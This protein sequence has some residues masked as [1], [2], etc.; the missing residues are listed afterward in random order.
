MKSKSDDIAIIGMSGKF[1]GAN[2]VSELWENICAKKESIRSLSDDELRKAGVS[3]QDINDST[4]VKVAALLDDYDLFDPSFFKISPLEAELMDPQI[5]LLLQC[6]WETLEDAGY[7]QKEAQN[8][9]VFAGAGGITASYFTHFINQNDRFEKITASPTQLGNDKDF[10]ATYPSYKLNLTGPSVTVQT[11][12]STSLVALHQARLS[13]LGGECDMALAGGVSIRVPH[14]QGYHYKEGYIFSK[15]GH[16]KTFDKSADGVVF[17]SGLGLVLIKK[18]SAAIRDGDH[19]YA[20][21]KGSAIVNDGKGKLSYAASSARGQI[22]CVRVALGN[23]G[24]EADSI[25]FVEAHGTGTA[26]GDPEE[27]KALSA[28]FKEQTDK[29]AYCALGAVKTN[30]GHLEAASGIV[31]FIKAVLAVKYGL[32]PPTPNYANPNPRI[33]F[34]NSPFYVN[35]QLEQWSEGKRP[36]RAA[37]NS[38]G[39]GGTNAFVILEQHV[40]TRTLWKKAPATPCVI[41]LS[42]KSESSLRAYAQRLA[43]FLAVCTAKEEAIH[44]ADVAYTLQVGREAMEYR[45]AFVVS[46]LDALQAALDRYLQNGEM[47]YGKGDAADLAAAWVGTADVDW[48]K[49]YVGVK[50]QRVS[51]PTYVFAQERYWIENENTAPACAFIHPLLHTN[52]SEL[53]EQKYSSSF[54]GEETFLIDHQVRSKQHGVNGSQ[55]RKILPGVAYLEMARAAIEQAVPFDYKDNQIQLQDILW[56]KPIVVPEERQVNIA[57]VAGDVD[58]QADRAIDFEIYT[59]DD[60]IHCQGRCLLSNESV[61]D[62]IDTI[63][64]KES[65]HKGRQSADSLYAAFAEMGLDYGPAHRAITAI[66]RGERELLAQLKLPPTT[67]AEQTNYVLHPS[68]M[69]GALQAAT[70]LLFDQDGISNQHPI[71]PFALS[72]LRI[73]APCTTEMFAWARHARNSPQSDKSA[74]LDVDLLDQQGNL[75]VQIRGF[76]PRPLDKEIFG[77]LLA[78]RVWQPSNQAA[79][80]MECVRYQ[81]ILCDLPHIDANKITDDCVLLELDSLADIAQCYSHLALACFAKAQALIKSRPQDK[82]LLQVV[83][84]NTEEQSVYAGL[85]GLFKTVSM[86][87][88]LILGQILLVDDAIGTDELSDL[89]DADRAHPHDTLI[90]YEKGVRHTTSWQILEENE[91]GIFDDDS[92]FKEWG[93]YLITGGLGR[94]GALFAKEILGRVANASIILTGQ[95]APEELRTLADKRAILT[96]LQAGGNTVEYRQLDLNSLD[97]VCEIIAMI[98]E[99]HG[100]LNGIIHSAGMIADNF[101]LKKTAEDFYRVLAPKVLGTFHLDQATQD[102]DLDFLVLFSSLTSATGNPG[103]ADYAAANGFMDEY[104]AHRNRLGRAGKRRGF[105]LAIRW[106]LWRDGGMQPHATGRDMLHETTGIHPMQT[107]TG[108]RM[109]YRSLAFPYDQ[110]LVMEGDL[111]SMQRTLGVGATARAAIPTL[112]APQQAPSCATTSDLVELTESYLCKQLSVLLKLPAHRIDPQALLEDYGIDSILALDLTGLLEKTFGPLSKTLFF[113]YLTI[114]ELAGYFVKAH[115]DQ[116]SQLFS[117]SNRISSHKPGTTPIPARLES[118]SSIRRGHPHLA[119]TNSKILAKKTTDSADPIA[120]IGLSG[121]YPGG[122]NLEEFWHN[123]R[124]GKDCIIEVP[125][126]RWDWREYYSADRSEQGCHYSKWGGFIEGVD[127]FDARFFHISPLEAETIDPQE[128]LFLEHA[129]MAIEDAGYTR[130]S[131]Q[132][133]EENNLTAQVGVY[134][135]VM[136]GEYQLFGAEASL[137]GNRMGF[138]SN[139]AS[140]ANRVSYFLN[141]HGPSMAV[142]TMCSSSL[143]AIHLACQDLELERTSLGIAGGVNV[144]IH[145]NKY[146][147]LSAGQFISSDGHCQSFGE[148]GD[149]YIPGEGVGV[150]VL[151]QLSAAQR[152]GNH[153]YGIIR[154]SALSHG[155]K[156][157]GYTVPNPQAQ[158]SAIRRALAEANVNPRHISYIEAHGTGTKLGDPIEIA[159]LSKVFQESTQDNEFCLIGS[160]KSNIGHCEAAAGIAGL[161]KAL[162]QLKHQAIVPSLHSSRL[163]PHIDFRNSPFVVNQSLR[164]WEQPVVEGATLPRIAGVSSFGAGGS[165]AHLIVEEYLQPITAAH[166]QE[167]VEVIVPLSARTADQLRMKARDLLEFVRDS[168][169]PLVSI[170]YTLQVGREAMEERLCILATSVEALADKLQAYLEGRTVPDGVYQGQ[171]KANKEA[172][173]LLE[174]DS[175]LQATIDK[176]IADGKLAKLADLWARGLNLNWHGFHAVKPPLV[177]LP[178][179]P[180][181][182]QR[183]WIETAAAAARQSPEALSA[184]VLHPLLHS[185]T[186]DFYQQSYTATFEGREFF[187]A[188]TP[189]Q[190]YLMEAACLEMARAAIEASMPAPKESSILELQDVAWAQP[191]IVAEKQPLGITLFDKVGEQVKFEIYR[192]ADGTTAT[193]DLVHCQGR[194]TYSDQPAPARIDRA[195]LEAEGGQS[196]TQLHLAAEFEN[197]QPD[198]VLHPELVQTA[199]QAAVDLTEGGKHPFSMTLLRVIFPCTKAKF[200]WARQSAVIRSAAERAI[201]IDL[202]DENGNVCVQMRGLRYQPTND[203]IPAAP[204][205]DLPLATPQPVALADVDSS[206][207]TP[208]RCD[209]ALSIPRNASILDKPYGSIVLLA[210]DASRT[211]TVNASQSGKPKVSLATTAITETRPREEERTAS[212]VSLFE[213]G[214]GVFSMHIHAPQS[215]NALSVDLVQD[216]LRALRAVELSSTAKVLTIEGTDGS[217]LTGGLESHNHAVVSG[218][219]RAIT[220]FPYPVVAVAGGDTTGAGFLFASVCDFIICSEVARYAFTI[221]REGLY[222]SAA[223]HLF[224]ERYG[225][226]QA[227]DFLYLSTVATGAELKSKGWTCPILPHD[228]VAAQ[229][230]DLAANLAQKPQL[231]LR[232]LKQQLVQHIS[233]AVQAL[234]VADRFP[235]VTKESQPGTMKIPSKRIRLDVQGNAVL[236]VTISEQANG[237]SAKDLLADLATVFGKIDEISPYR[238]VVLTSNLAGFLPET[239][240]ASHAD[241]VQGYKQAL[242]ALKRPIVAALIADATGIAW[243]V[244]QFCDTCLY[245]EQGRYSC[246]DILHDPKLAEEAAALFSLRFGDQVAKEILMAGAACSG[247]ELRDIYGAL[248]VFSPKQ[249]LPDALRLADALAGFPAPVLAGWKKQTL[250]ILQDTAK[251]LEDG[252]PRLAETAQATTDA[253][254]AVALESRVISAIAHPEGILEVH[255]ADHDAHNMFSDAF[256]RGMREVFAH[257]EDSRTYKVVVLTGYDHY[258]ASGAT[259]DTLLAIFEGKAKFTDNK[260]F[261]LPLTCTVPVIAAMQG[262]GIG[263][264]WAM[265]MYADFALFSETGRYLSPYMGYGFTPGAG[266]TLIFLEKMGYDLAREGLLSAREY[267][268]AELKARG[269]RNPVLARELV[270]PAAMTLAKRIAQGSRGLLVALKRRWAERLR[271]DL[272][273]TFERELAMHARTI[274]G[275]T[276]TLTRIQSSF[277]APSTPLAQSDSTPLPVPDESFD[278]IMAS[279]KKLLAHELR[280]QEQEIGEDEQFVDL[281]LDSITGVTWIRRINETYATSIEATKIYSYPTLAQLARYVQEQMPQQAAPIVTPTASSVITSPGAESRTIAANLRRLLAHELRMQENEIGDDEQFVDLGLDSITGV[282]WMRKINE[283]YKISIE[284][285]K[286]YSYPTLMQLSRYVGEEVAKLGAFLD[287]PRVDPPVIPVTTHNLHPLV[288][289]LRSWRDQSRSKGVMSETTSGARLQPIAVIGMAGQF[290]Q[291]R[292]LEKFWQNIAEG[293][294]C[295]EEIPKYRWNIDSYYQEG[296]AVPGKTYS[297]WMGLLEEY[298]RFDAG[299]FNISPREARSMDPQQRLFLQACWHSIEHAGYNPKSLSGSNCGVFVGCSAGDYHQL[300]KHEQLSGQGFT[301]A[302]PSVLAARISYFLDLHGPSLSIDTAC[303]SSLVAIAS[304]CDSLISNSSDIALAGGVN[305]MSSPAMQIMTAQVGML[306]PQGRCL[307]FDDKADGIVNGEGVGVLMLKRLADAQRDRDWIYGVLEGWGVNQDGR[308]N[309][310]TAPNADL[311]A[312]LQQE[313]YDRFKIDPASIQLIEAHGTGTALGDPIEVAGLKASFK[314]YTCEKNYCALGS[315]KSNI[316][317]CLT[318]AGVSGVIKTLLALEHQQLPP[319]IHFHTLNKHISLQDSPFYIN[320]RLR[321]WQQKDGEPRRA[322]INSFGFSGTNAHVVIAEYQWPQEPAAHDEAA[323]IPLSARTANQ[324]QQKAQ[325]LLAIVNVQTTVTPGLHDIAYTLQV[326]R[327]AM[328]ERVAFIA[329]TIAELKH[330]L[331]AFLEWEDEQSVSPVDTMYR[332]KASGSQDT[333]LTLSSDADFQSMI[334]KWIDKK[335]LPRL[336]D[337]WVKGLALDWNNFYIAEKSPRRIGLPTYPFAKERYWIDAPADTHSPISATASTIIHPLL[338]TNTSDLNQQK[339]TTQLAGDEFFLIDC[340][341]PEGGKQQVFPASACLEM[342]RVAVENAIPDLPQSATIEL[343]AIKWGQPAKVGQIA[344]ALSS[345]GTGRLAFDIF[346]VEQ[347]EVIHCQ[348]QVALREATAAETLDCSLRQGE[349]RRGEQTPEQLYAAFA[350]SG[351]RYSAMQRAIQEILPGDGELLVRLALPAAVDGTLGAYRIHPI[352]MDGAI[353]AGILLLGGPGDR[354]TQMLSP[355]TIDSVHVFSP[356]TQEMFAR[357]RCDQADPRL[358]DIDLCDEYGNPCVQV[359]GMALEV[360]ESTTPRSEHTT[361]TPAGMQPVAPITEQARAATVQSSVSPEQ[362]QQQLKA[363]LAEALFMQPADVDI[364]K[365]FTELGL[366]S[367]IGVEWVNVINK[368]YGTDIAATRIYDYPSIRELASF[369]SKEMADTDQSQDVADTKDACTTVIAPDNTSS[370]C[371]PEARQDVSLSLRAQTSRHGR[372]ARFARLEPI[373][374]EPKYSE[375]FKELYFYSPDGAGDFDATGEFSVQYVINPD[376]NLCLREHVVFDEHLLPTDAY[377]ELVHCAYQAYFS[378]ENIYLRDIAIVNPLLGNKGRDTY[379]QIVFRRAGDDLQFFVKSSILPTFKDSSLHMQGFV[380]IAGE[381]PESGFE[382]DFPIEKEI[383]SAEIPT[384]TGIY[385]APLQALRFGETAAIGLIKV[386]DHAFEFLV[387]PFVLYGGLCTVINFG[388]YLAGKQDRLGN[389]QFLPYRIGRIRA[390]GSLNGT[391]YRCYAR[392]KKLER[393]SIEFD[394]EILDGSEQPVLTIDTIGLRRVAKETIQQQAAKVKALPLIESGAA[395]DKIAII[396][397][398][399]RY[400]MSPDIDAFWNN[401]KAGRDCIT[402][403]P[404]KR[405]SNHADWYHPDPSHAHTSYSKWGGFLDDIDTFDALFFGISPAEAEVIDPQ[406]RIFLE[407]CWKTIE[408]AGYASSAL[409]NH[410]CGVYV[411]CSTGDYSRVLANG[412]QDTVGAAFMGTSNAILAARVSYHL[413]LKGPALAIDTACSS[414]LVAVHLACESIRSGENQLALAGGI[415]ILTTPIGHILT[416]QV[417]MPSRD[418][419]CPAFD[420]SANGIVFSEGCGVLL[421]KALSLAKRDNDNILGVI[422]GSGINQDGKTNGITAPSSNAQEQLLKQVYDKFNIDPQRIGYVEAHGTATPLGDPIEV[423][424]LSSV[425]GRF[426]QEKKYCA[427]GSVKSNI[428]HTG[429]AAGVAGILKVLLCIKHKKLVPSIHYHKPN[430][431]IDFENSP[432]FVNTQYCDWVSDQPLLATVSSFGFSGTNAHVV[433]EE[434]LSL[435]EPVQIGSGAVPNT[436]MFVPLSARTPEQLGQKARDLLGFIHNAEYP[437]D[438]AQMAHTLLVG[439][440]AMEHRLGFIVDS[441]EQLAVKLQAYLDGKVHIDDCYRGQ[442]GRDND[443]LA[444]FAGDMEI[445]DLIRRWIAQNNLPKI[446]DLWVKGFELDGSALFDGARPTRMRLPTYP[447]AKERCWISTVEPAMPAKAENAMATLHPLLHCNTSDLSQQSYSSTFDGNEFFLADHRVGGQQMLPAVAYLEMARAALADAMPVQKA[448]LD[449]ELHHI[450]WTQPIFV[451]AKQD[452]EIAVFS[453]QD[454]Q[455]GF[456]I[457]SQ[458]GDDAEDILHCQGSAII[459]DQTAEQRLDLD[460]L[461]R[462]MSQGSLEG[463]VLYPLFASMGLEYGPTFQGITALHRGENQLLVELNL[464][465]AARKGSG[466]YVLHPSLMDA[467][468]QG[469]ITLIDDVMHGSGKRSLPFALDSLRILSVCTERMVAWVRYAQGGRGASSNLIKVDIDLCDADGNVCVQMRG[470]S[471]RPMANVTDFDEAHYRSVIAGISNREISLDE[472]VELG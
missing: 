424:A 383:G 320:D 39:I 329:S 260:V 125:K 453:E 402:E 145:P 269:L 133:L 379:V 230:Q 215:R 409:S 94:L 7:A 108:M 18:L 364:H 467:A 16:V 74:R 203:H 152:D 120:I 265:G 268:G 449:L 272:P 375:R 250:S 26:M 225:L 185:N 346:S 17:G 373:C 207:I 309:G 89:L 356:C 233:S 68:L 298:D 463:S 438:L 208:D 216:I 304:A 103:Q 78:T 307:A 188:G 238:C 450:V 195:V 114:R 118:I 135:G 253:P 336:A 11:A 470:F 468:L 91:P 314:K 437:L 204:S 164:S 5:R 297:K 249:V 242:L 137:Q 255:M 221:A 34:E 166:A 156:T 317:H 452:I 131:L 199:L 196:L 189:G 337:L 251:H 461:R 464:P 194:A 418:G 228:K 287:S 376:N 130:A 398:S 77:S 332:G 229:A 289:S 413:N 223:D 53:D 126:E 4:Y 469:S 335:E 175:D 279:I 411:G 345:Q 382:A 106:P 342:T 285:T 38:L 344:I 122:R 466:N 15:S 227:T 182:R 458:D 284:A 121:R 159:A 43:N 160:V 471:S 75:C 393:E 281:G 163:N 378:P 248:H 331:R 102:L 151:K 428:G 430:P 56:F 30:V 33:K 273:A 31:G 414:S 132:T 27:V 318:A 294:D 143:T 441:T 134:A 73:V 385:Y 429:F 136:Y 397:M 400:P 187:L 340:D 14:V 267:S 395:A 147:M 184:A 79:E 186:S 62:R 333:L 278:A 433:I 226:V 100:Q 3:E 124:N 157:N 324:L 6:A 51:L 341:T 202:F 40:P 191:G 60:Q 209:S 392:V 41:P 46:T 442:T 365:S 283:A 358:A 29:K 45:V 237:C 32:I 454:A 220:E 252:A 148:G 138:A 162:L 213:H 87:N 35:G 357:V 8:I 447:F 76:M 63:Q 201:D 386:P 275:Q 12:C 423:N 451:S 391:D 155:G 288:S 271:E 328:D 371:M 19:I 394:F 363:S 72:S 117:D 425:F 308:T 24:V 71:V 123:L 57:V 112:A 431:H 49:L 93:V 167:A 88:S 264:G 405:W 177:S 64:L 153:I 407:E 361:A 1:P 460:R 169:P 245:S 325:D 36:R 434:H 84:P 55:W 263:A 338:H 459:S 295:I 347:E 257:V 90:K 439:R 330:K 419:R 280:M 181:A 243:H 387:S 421:L 244:A 161:T 270:V 10:L 139:L 240:A 168:P 306:S 390:L 171:V 266:S 129:W 366:D 172:L 128:R 241:V 37:V 315:V 300:S 115:A 218:L 54:T 92:P 472:A 141:L 291:A 239:S 462:Q 380:S 119:N 465:E 212:A 67:I 416:S 415:N 234:T 299:F 350:K 292:D 448:W 399:C 274:A 170:A 443:M 97:Q 321:P 70:A 217:F 417:G 456:E 312:R 367:I 110:T 303:S 446:V 276:D 258:F 21:I 349:G 377:I 323:I 85:S 381:F 445:R 2:S 158:A 13:L 214:N 327:E 384:N 404:A 319:T 65:M 313:V 140:I 105:T 359:R 372:A 254:I 150:V 198:Y 370:S 369:L 339:Y 144:T 343:Y 322:A 9:G 259:R 83:M 282:T 436:K 200:S 440:D 127:E 277:G 193:Q 301:G 232:L 235:L 107:S 334:A 116:L 362:L 231:S 408:S 146:L 247:A 95:A 412:S 286:V 44:I 305:V 222:P 302:A 401:L 406:Q 427:L 104:A 455:T 48:H 422:Q 149:G 311:Q 403:V 154:G 262:H 99:K 86:E 296:K 142:D 22:T 426:T 210:P 368:Q 444:S 211:Q 20:I 219:Y 316:G 173:S 58:G 98:R 374:F 205:N 111:P 224:S 80:Q 178:A 326:G 290:A 236:I 410:A 42:A 52:T 457:Y 25:G 192:A 47:E 183:F 174:Q 256:T 396:G 353:Q 348:G 355:V 352:L 180:F 389:D 354:V 197:S 310:I 176:W 432:F 28:A 59:R 66:D 23:A 360:L 179:Y 388:A 82:M 435:A 351:V 81:V 109:F 420:A 69:D 261:Q 61:Q 96:S 50:P 206:R 113:E 101:I 190:K 293:K 165:N 246:A